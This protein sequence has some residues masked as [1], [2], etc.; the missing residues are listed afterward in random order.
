MEM[1]IEKKIIAKQDAQKTSIESKCQLTSDIKSE[2]QLWMTAEIMG[3]KMIQ[4]KKAK[5]T[6]EYT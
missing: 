3:E 1:K 2:K 5:N 6:L 4:R